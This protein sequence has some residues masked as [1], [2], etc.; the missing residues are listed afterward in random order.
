VDRLL[1][2]PHYGERWGRHWLDVARYADTAGDDADYPVPQAYR[3][4]NYVIDAFNKDKPYDQFIREQIAGDLLGGRT[5]EERYERIVATGFLALAR[6]S[7]EDPDKEPHIT[8]DDAIDTL[9][10]TILGIS[11]SCARCHDHKFDPIPKEDYYAIYGI[12]ASSRFAYA[13][14]DHKKYQRD[15]VPLLPQDQADRIARPFDERLAFLEAQLAPLDKEAQDFEKALGGIVQDSSAKAKKR[16]LKELKD[17]LQAAQKE[18]EKFGKTR[19][20]YPDAFAVSEGIAGNAR[21]Q[22]AGNPS[23]LGAEVPR[24]FVQ[25]LGGGKVPAD[26]QGS[27]RRQLAEW[28]T[29]PRNPVTAR[30]MVNRLWQ[31]HFGRGLVQ[32]PD[33]FGK[34]GKPPTHPELLDFLANQLVQSGWSIKAMHRQMLLSHTYRLSAGEDAANSRIDPTNQLWWRADCRRLG[35]EAIRDSLLAVSGELERGVAGAHPFPPRKDWNYG[36]AA[37]FKAVYETKRRSIYLL[38]PRVTRDSFLALF[39]GADA[40]FSV[41]QRFES[42]T[43][44][45]ALYLMNS[46][47]VS[48]QAR[49]FAGRLAKL[50]PDD[51]GRIELAHRLLFGRPASP[52]ETADGLHYLEKLN[53]LVPGSDE[54]PEVVPKQREMLVATA[55][56]DPVTWRYVFQAPPKEWSEK[57]F[58]DAAWSEGSA[59]FA[60]RKSFREPEFIARTVWDTPEIWLRRRFALPERRWEHPWLRVNHGGPAEVYLNGVLAADLKGRSNGYAHFEI[61]KQAL[62]TLKS[63]ENL[64]AI[65]CHG[66][67][68]G[69]FVDAGLVERAGSQDDAPAAWTSYLRVLMSSNE[70][71]YV[72]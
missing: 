20:D 15:F 2:S 30:V 41:G 5:E 64:L 27:G 18:C 63:G 56:E 68:A 48:E 36:G 9:G 28:L 49:A 42:T 23:K 11:L 67:G 32:T 26:E 7:G 37:P 53:R 22:I 21:V 8:L 19:P 17:A 54:V 13:G 43:S 70:F 57:A 4:R 1:A 31:H 72:D 3:Y 44:V 16:T 46:P 66:A 14:S 33:V 58:Q 39:D 40:N 24:G 29:D 59:G 25:V 65:H 71:F 50:R 55:H 45:Q 34:Q 10:K 51:G 47:F 52:E 38:Q 12:L 60:P 62:A 6:R 69:Q 61:R 35:A